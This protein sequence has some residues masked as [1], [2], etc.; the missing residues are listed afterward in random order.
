MNLAK[1]Q[2][3]KKERDKK[4]H[5]KVLLRREQ[6]QKKEKEINTWN[7]KERNLQSKQVPIKNDDLYKARQ[8]K[9]LEIKMQLQHNMKILKALEEES[10]KEENKLNSTENS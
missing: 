10:L 2:A 5:K 6:K 7:Q 3:K 9:D 8:L 1:K 4:A